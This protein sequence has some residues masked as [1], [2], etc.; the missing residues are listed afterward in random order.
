[1][2]ATT[3]WSLYSQVTWFPSLDSP[4]SIT[5][6]LRYTDEEKEITYLHR[7]LENPAGFF[8][9]FFAGMSPAVTYSENADAIN[10]PEVAGI[11]GRSFSRV[12]R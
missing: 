10:Q 3:A 7:S 6:G 4:F 12:A 9:P 5:G 11:F 1:M 8:G 2:N